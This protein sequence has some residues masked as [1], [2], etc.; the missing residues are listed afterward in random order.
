M[1]F[2][3]ETHVAE[4]VTH[5][6]AA[7]RVF[8]RYGIDFCCGGKRPLAEVC[9]ERQL[10]AERLLQE[11]ATLAPGDA[12]EKDW[13]EA[14]LQTIVQH[15]LDRYHSPLREELPR[16]SYMADKVLRVHGE[17]F[18]AMIPPVA[19]RLQELRMELESHMMKEERMLFPYVV[20]LEQSWKDGRSFPGSPFGTVENPI[21][22]MEAEHEDAGRLLA[23]M[24][25][26]TDGYTLPE[27]ACNT[28]RALFHGLEQLEK[29]MHLHVHLENNVLFPRAAELERRMAVHA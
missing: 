15:I 9:Q 12:E 3:P 26:L 18:P 2:T 25:S 5:N 13:S 11:I 4:I 6:P 1:P 23:E 14:P 8:H 27:G 7:T 19:A 10:D 22:M 24:R 28:F 20:T 16:L 17:R 21:R 29:E